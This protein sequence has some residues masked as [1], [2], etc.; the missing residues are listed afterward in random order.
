MASTAAARF[1]AMRTMAAAPRL[2]AAAPVRGFATEKQIA[3]RIT[4]TGNLMK[5]TSSMKMVSAAK[6][7]GDQARLA[8]AGPFN[9][10]AATLSPPSMA[11]EDLDTTAWPQT[12]LVVAISTDKGLCGGVNGYIARAVRDI[13][14]S[15][16][17]GNKDPAS[18][19]VFGEKGRGPVRRLAGDSMKFAATDAIVPYSYS[20]VAAFATD[21]LKIDPTSYEQIHIVYNKFESAI[22]YTTSVQSLPSLAGEGLDE[23][24]VEYS[25]EPDTKSEVMVDMREALLSSQLYYCIMENA[26]SEITART[27]AMENASKNAGELIEALTLQYNKARQTRITTELIEIISGAAALE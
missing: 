19:V 7:K 10:W 17:A 16:A 1:A 25:F 20:T 13:Q 2:A 21:V 24:M 5:I 18:V 9:Q 15:L 11:V 8:I 14:A 12:N 4:S 6:T 22:S 23:P 27:A 3:M 26:L